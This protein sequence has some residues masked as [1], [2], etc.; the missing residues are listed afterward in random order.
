MSQDNLIKLISLGDDEG[1]GKGHII[2]AHKNTKK[3]KERLELKKYN[4]V[5]KKHTVYK[6]KKSK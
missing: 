4:P 1:V 5:A 2:W 6:E 3:L